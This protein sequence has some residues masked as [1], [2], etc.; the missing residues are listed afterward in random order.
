M[1]SSN[2][3]ARTGCRQ[4]FP[5]ARLAL[6]SPHRFASRAALVVLLVAGTSCAMFQP[7]ESLGPTPTITSAIPTTAQT[8]AD[9]LPPDTSVGTA[10][11]TTATTGA[12][13]TTTSPLTAAPLEYLD[14]LLA[15]EADVADL[16][17]D[18]QVINDDWDD[19]SRTGVSF[20]E[21]ETAL[22]L[23]VDRARELEESF[24]LIE[25]PSEFGLWDEH[26]IA[27]SSVGI[28]SA[29]PQEMLDGL[30]SPDAGH[31]RRAALVGFLT[32]FDLFKQVIERVAAIIGEDGVALLETRRS[33]STAPATTLPEPDTTLAEST[34]TVVEPPPTSIIGE[35]PPNPGN[36][37]NCSDFATQAESQQWYDT[38]Y[39]YYGDVAKLDTNDNGAACEFL[40]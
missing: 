15:T 29:A 28:M 2:A 27:S 7:E 4:F 26:R 31:A 40:P 13:T 6:A 33:Q 17:G 37:K 12:A 30:R 20:A 24:S 38:Y 39:P 9:P 8:P 32:A 18:V 16:A 5:V 34:A 1:E 23:T 25:V 22:E 14:R 3:P 35:A 11:E 10:P 36:S 21:T 19:R